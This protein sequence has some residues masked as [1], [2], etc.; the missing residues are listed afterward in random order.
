MRTSRLLLTTSAILVVICVAPE[1]GQGQG[2]CTVGAS[3]LGGLESGVQPFR[4]LTAGLN[5]QFNSL[6]RAF[7]GRERIDDPLRR[8]A[9]VSYLTLQMELGLAPFV[10]LLLSFPYSDKSRE[11]TVRTGTGDQQTAL[12]RGT[13]AG[14]VT[15]LAKYQ[16]I[17]PGIVSPFELAVG[18]GASLP[19]GSFTQEQDGSQ[20]SI[21]L[22]PGT[23]AVSVIGWMFALRSVPSV[24]VTVSAAVQYRYS[25]TN[26]DGYRLGDELVVNTGG[27]YQLTS[28]LR[29]ALHVRARFAGQDYANRRVL[30]ATGGTY[31][32]L[33][34][35]LTYAEGPSVV[36]AFGQLPLYRNVRGIQ[37]TLSYL[38]GVEYRY[39]FDFRTGAAAVTW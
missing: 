26:F 11:I 37:L 7:Q 33:M 14:D 38:L 15:V 36:R 2:C 35:G 32:D 29:S 39:T 22:Q 28:Y 21:D 9:T 4:T 25:G 34:P 1:R 5:Y 18:G 13:G 27:E 17:S 19:T 20:L 16:L 12:F 6:T 23:G 10:S 8:V 24:G 30:N 3:S 31:Y